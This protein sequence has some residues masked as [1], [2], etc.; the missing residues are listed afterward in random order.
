MALSLLV[1][2]AGVYF[3]VLTGVCQRRFPS[4]SLKALKNGA[5]GGLGPF[6]ALSAALSGTMG[7]GSLLAVSTALQLGGP[8]ALFWMWV[9]GFFGMAV[10]YGEVYLCLRHREGGEGGVMTAL[11]GIGCLHLASLYALFVLAAC[12]FSIGG[13]AQSQAAAVALRRETGLPPNACAWTLAA[14]ALALSCLKKERLG[15][16]CA[17]CFPAVAGLYACGCLLC[18]FLRRAALPEALL[19][20]F[21]EGLSPR[22]FL[23]GSGLAALR[24]GVARGLFANEAGLGTSA[25]AHSLSRVRDARL[26]AGLGMAEVFVNTHLLSTLTALVLLCAPRGLSGDGTGLALRAFG[27]VLGPPGEELVSVMVLFFALSTMPVWLLYGRRAARFLWPRV[28][29]RA[30]DAA[31]TAV[32]L[33]CVFFGALAEQ[34]A[35]WRFADVLN[36]GLCLPSLFLLFRCRRE[37]RESCKAWPVP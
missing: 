15:A 12:L 2:A 26:Q 16:L 32:Y 37:I 30:V 19:S 29:N 14:A 17:L 3:T 21:R 10:K 7:V 33:I 25:M 18:L 35:L 11:R 27:S 24:Y 23:S 34:A 22:A 4:L 36:L 9:G 13:M 20:V 1:L 31:V 8:G 28:Q 5:G 6:E